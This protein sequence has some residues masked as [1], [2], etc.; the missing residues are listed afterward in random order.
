MGTL[1]KP[2]VTRTFA[3]VVVEE[4]LMP[5]TL[6]AAIRRLL[7]TCFPAD[8]TVFSNTRHWHGSAPAYSLVH[9][10]SDHVYG[11]VGVVVRTIRC[12]NRDVIVAGI[13]N[14]ALHPTLRGC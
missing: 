14:L 8:E 7:C 2:N 13:Q 4:S 12:G 5:P 6:D 1:F 11:H 10:Q 9:V 3:L